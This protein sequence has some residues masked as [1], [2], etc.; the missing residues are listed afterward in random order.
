MTTLSPDN[1]QELIENLPPEL[2][3]RVT[4][5]F[6][7]D[8]L[9]VMCS[10]VD[11]LNNTE[12]TD[13]FKTQIDD[14]V[15]EMQSQLT[16]RLGENPTVERK[17]TVSLDILQELLSSFGEQPEAFESKDEDSNSED[18]LID[19]EATASLFDS[20]SDDKEEVTNSDE[21]NIQRVAN[22]E[23]VANAERVVNSNTQPTQPR[24]SDM[25]RRS[26]ENMYLFARA[27]RGDSQNNEQDNGIRFQEPE[28]Q[29][30]SES[31]RRIIRN[32]LSAQGRPMRDPNPNELQDPTGPTGDP[33]V[34]RP[35][36]DVT[37]SQ[38]TSSFIDEENAGDY[39]RSLHQ[40]LNPFRISDISLRAIGVVDSNGR[41]V[42][43]LEFNSPNPIL[44]SDFP[45]NNRNPVVESSS[46]L[47]VALDNDRYIAY[48]EISDRG[49]ECPICI[50][51]I[52]GTVVVTPCNHRFCSRCLNR[53]YRNK[54]ECPMCRKA[55]TFS[56]IR[57]DT[58]A[59]EYLDRCLV[60]CKN[61]D[62]KQEITRK[63]EPV[64]SE[65]CEYNKSECLDCKSLV[66]N[67][68][69]ESHRQCCPSR[70]T[71][72]NLC[73]AML[74]Y[75]KYQSHLDTEC[76]YSVVQCKNQDCNYRCNRYK[77]AVHSRLNCRTREV[78]CPSGCG[79]VFKIGDVEGHRQVC[80]KKSKPNVE[81]E[82]ELEVTPVY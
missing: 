4:D 56:S 42:P 78:E 41:P 47:F 72:C 44:E 37:E 51:V 43:I 68:D 14:A 77:M 76:P 50:S 36:I 73:R 20:D 55:F 52:T 53:H 81:I 16:Q 80:S 9:R 71:T 49:L 25:L 17:V 26:R 10:Y 79:L 60:T 3:S 75:L 5:L 23:R 70:K 2:A 32:N 57:I 64:H 30:L 54:P 74:P 13:D 15:G 59:T 67:R 11:S 18:E 69:L 58:E 27:F 82:D 46:D 7:S 63:D 28:P 24:Q 65:S 8:N 48:P 33:G 40:L 6:N 31:R 12:L 34:F 19:G 21:V 61:P 35:M 66:Y 38:D 62:Y 39:L 45:E 1:I 29:V 22:D